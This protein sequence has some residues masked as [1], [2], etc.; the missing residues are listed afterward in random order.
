[1]VTDSGDLVILA[2]QRRGVD[3]TGEHELAVGDTMLLGGA[4]EALD[5]NLDGP[6]VLVVDAPQAVRRQAVPL[7][8]GAGRAAFV[9]IALIAVLV[10]GQPV[11]ASSP[12]WSPPAR[13]SRCG[14]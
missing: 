12:A 7:G 1:M 14:C 10:S 5:S 3:L 2:L 4:W 8:P 13:W 6:E 11:P 9:L